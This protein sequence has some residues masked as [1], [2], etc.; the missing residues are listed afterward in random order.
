LTLCNITDEALLAKLEAGEVSA[1]LRAFVRPQPHGRKHNRPAW[2]QVH[3][4][5]QNG[6]VEKIQFWWNSKRKS[7]MS[8]SRKLFDGEIT[9]MEIKKIQD[10]GGE[11]LSACGFSSLDEALAYLHKTYNVGDRCMRKVYGKMIQVYLVR[12]RRL[13]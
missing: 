9:G 1:I 4:R 5:F 10:L 6:S 3:K 7:S 11:D 13:D 12:F 2:A 8:A